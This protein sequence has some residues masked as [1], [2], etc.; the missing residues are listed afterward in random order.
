MSK[1]EE[2]TNFGKETKTS[3]SR[4]HLTWDLKDVEK[5]TKEEMGRTISH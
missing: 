4:G 3:K 2:T 1:E 5:I